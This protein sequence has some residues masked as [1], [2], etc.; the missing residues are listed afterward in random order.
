MAIKREIRLRETGDGTWT[1]TDLTRGISA[2]GESRAAALDA[3]DGLTTKSGKNFE[4]SLGDRLK[5]MA[6]DIDAG[7]VEEV[8]DIRKRD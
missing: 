1:A 6:S 8:R 2:E 3:L 5:G 4:E 7:S